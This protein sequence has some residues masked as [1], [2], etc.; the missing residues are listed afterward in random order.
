[1]MTINPSAIVSNTC[2]PCQTGTCIS[3]GWIIVEKIAVGQVPSSP[4]AVIM[5][6]PWGSIG[7]SMAWRASVAGR[8]WRSLPMEDF[9]LRGERPL[10][11]TCETLC[12]R[13]LMTE[14]APFRRLTWFIRTGGYFRRARIVVH[15]LRSIGITGSTLR[16]T[17]R[18]WMSSRS[19]SFQ[20]PTIK[21]RRFLYRSR[22]TPPRPRFPITF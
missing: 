1:M 21:A 3:R 16:G 20:R 7:R 19:C 8:S 17:R 2:W 5:E 4:R 13:G 6:R 14:V 12:W 9:G 22:C 15:R 10:R 18:A 11:G